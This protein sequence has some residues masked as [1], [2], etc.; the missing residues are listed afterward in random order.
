MCKPCVDP[1]ERNNFCMACI[2]P[3]SCAFAQDQSDQGLLQ[4]RRNVHR[5]C[6]NPHCYYGYYFKHI[7]KVLHGVFIAFVVR[8]DT[9]RARPRERGG[10][11]ERRGGGKRMQAARRTEG[12]Q[13][14]MRGIS[15][16]RNR[17]KGA[18]R[19]DGGSKNGWRESKMKEEHRSRGDRGVERI[20][21]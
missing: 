16:E 5:M 1:R 7:Q 18:G 10:D 17:S 12:E 20:L 6:L 8:F 3:L 9:E 21:A 15:T 14:R 19:R 13:E 2:V 4:F 11:G